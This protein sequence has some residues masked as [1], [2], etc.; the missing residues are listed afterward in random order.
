MATETEAGPSMHDRA[1]SGL[2]THLAWVIRVQIGDN[3]DHSGP[4]DAAEK[5]A[6]AMVEQAENILLTGDWRNLARPAHGPECMN[7]SPKARGRN[8]TS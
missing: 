6:A 1:I 2:A 7:S 4:E 8:L 3:P 5:L